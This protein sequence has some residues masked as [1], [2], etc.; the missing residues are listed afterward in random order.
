MN[1]HV[2]THYWPEPYPS[3]TPPLVSPR[4]RS[5]EGA[6]VPP[7]YQTR[8]RRSCAAGVHAGRSSSLRRRLRLR[9]LPVPSPRSPDGSRLAGHRQSGHAAGA[10]LQ[11]DVGGP[12][13]GR[14]G[15]VVRR[16]PWPDDADGAVQCGR[17]RVHPDPAGGMDDHARQHQ[18]TS[19]AGHHLHR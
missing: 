10:L 2:T 18:S 9:R 3:L 15:S 12:E 6:P 7:G 8:H 4:S 14:S 19:T 17:A 11:A 5:R 1:A 16:T 13:G